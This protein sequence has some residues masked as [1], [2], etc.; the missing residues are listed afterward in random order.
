MGRRDHDG[1]PRRLLGQ[2]PQGHSRQRA[3]GRHHEA[4]RRHVRQA[5]SLLSERFVFRPTHRID[6]AR[7]E[8]RSSGKRHAASDDPH[9]QPRCSDSERRIGSAPVGRLLG[10]V[11]GGRRSRTSQRRR[12]RAL[13]SLARAGSI[14]A[15]RGRGGG[16]GRLVREGGEFCLGAP[17]RFVPRRRRVLCKGLCVHRPQEV[18]GALQ[19]P[20]FDV[21][22]C[23]V[24][25]EH[26]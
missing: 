17:P 10:P 19:L 9:E 21:G 18:T 23:A 14:G 1:K 8:I 24:Q 11:E 13:G 12:W 25:E 22:A 6:A 4:R 15:Q 5:T 7:L 2:E 16:R 3:H 26:G 20:E